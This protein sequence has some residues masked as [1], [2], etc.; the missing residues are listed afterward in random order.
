MI[1]T[2]EKG[3]AEIILTYK[4]GQFNILTANKLPVFFLNGKK[5]SLKT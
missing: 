2:A 5:L 3:V 4:P 1:F